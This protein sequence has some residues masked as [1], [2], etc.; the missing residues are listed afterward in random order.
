MQRL[1]V[2]TCLLFVSC[3]GVGPYFARSPD[4]KCLSRPKRLKRVN[5]IPE[6][7][8][9]KIIKETINCK[10]V[11]SLEYHAKELS[12]IVKNNDINYFK[13]TAYKNGANSIFLIKND[14]SS[15]FAKAYSCK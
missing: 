8:N 14:G 1:G 2:L 13:N 9:V 12:F 11:R 7:K 4:F 3:A 15:S 6:A 10:L 5:L